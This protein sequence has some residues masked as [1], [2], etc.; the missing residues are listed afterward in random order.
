MLFSLPKHATLVYELGLSVVTFGHR[1]QL[2][3]KWHITAWD[4]LTQILKS[5]FSGCP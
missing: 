3:H 2:G 1:C 5:R 4:L